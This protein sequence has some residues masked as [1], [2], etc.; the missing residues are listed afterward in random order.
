MKIPSLALAATLLFS[1]SS[2]AL[3]QLEGT[4]VSTDYENQQYTIKDTQTGEL[5]TMDF[6]ENTSIRIND[7]KYRDLSKL[8]V[9]ENVIYKRNV[10]FEKPKPSYITG[11]IKDLDFENQKVTFVDEN[12]EI[13][14]L[15]YQTD[16][17]TNSREVRVDRL[18]PGQKVVLEVV[19]R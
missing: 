1:S 8:P 4:I 9:G 12:G 15:D 5:H 6:K 17:T 11:T 7:R 16:G 14:T 2:F 18:R 13:K 3:T 19:S 10:R